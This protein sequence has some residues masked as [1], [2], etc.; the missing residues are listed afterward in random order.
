MDFYFIRHGQSENNRLWAQSGSNDSRV[1]DPCLTA[2]GERQAELLARFLAG[3]NAPTSSG[4][5]RLH[6]FH[7]TH[8]YTSLMERALA[9]GHR[10]AEA[11]D[12]PLLGWVDIHETGGMFLYDQ[13]TESYVP[14][15]GHSRSHLLRH[16]PRLVLPDE[17]ARKQE[18][19]QKQVTEAGWWNLPFEPKEVRAPRARQVL[20]ELLEKHEICSDDGVAFVSHGGFFN[21]L[22]RAIMGLPEREPVEERDPVWFAAYNA[23]ITHIAFVGDQRVVRYLNRVDFLSEDLLT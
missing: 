18:A 8:I 19:A 12:L 10:I 16:F 4:G 13:E 3:P 21:Y 2:I 15:P 11:L 14:Q 7:I 17:A 9:T 1:A 5:Q 6:K 20:A 22:M 23:S